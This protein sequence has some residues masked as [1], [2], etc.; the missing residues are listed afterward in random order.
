MM[1]QL[2]VSEG[3]LVTIKSATLPK[4]TF[5]KLQ[6]TDDTFMKTSNPK[7]ILENALRNW[8]TL[9]QDDTICVKYNSKN[10]YLKV[11]EVKPDTQSHAITIIDADVQVDFLASPQELAELTK[12]QEQRSLS[13]PNTETKSGVVFGSGG[14]TKGGQSLSSTSPPQPQPEEQPKF[15]GSGRR[16]KD[17]SPAEPSVASRKP[18][19]SSQTT[20]TTTSTTTSNVTPSPSANAAVS[21]SLNGSGGMVFG[22]NSTSNRT[23]QDKGK[24]KED[25]KT[26]EKPGWKAFS[27]TG[28]SLKG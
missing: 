21:R 3:G 5:T 6:P 16:I 11:L 27:G 4:G 8:A 7:A 22:S 14:L 12:Q 24:E 10:Y 23:T 17:G 18:V 2:L 25:E 13:N 19:V 20:S 15:P 28:Y 9:T 1:Q 26:E